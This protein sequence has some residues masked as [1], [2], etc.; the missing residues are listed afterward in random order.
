MKI[1]ITGG[2]G[3]IGKHLVRKLSNSK[4]HEILLLS[5]NLKDDVDLESSNIKLIEGNLSNI[6]EWKYEVKKFGPQATIHMAWEGIPDYGAETSIKNIK[7]GLDLFQMLSEIGCKKIISTGS[8]WEYGKQKGSLNEESTINP[9]NAFTSAKN[10]LH[11]IGKYFAEEKNM[12]FIWTRL[13]YVYGPGQRKISIIP[14]IID[15]IEQGKKPEIKTP[16]AK[17]DF[18]YVEDVVDAIIEI[19]EKGNK[20][21][22]YN[23]G[24]GHLT[25]VKKI[26][27]E[28]YK[29]LN[30][31]NEVGMSKNENESSYGEFWAD[32]SEIKREIGWEPKVNIEE[33]IS[34]IVRSGEKK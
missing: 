25:S 8:C 28:V 26:M 24:S 10:S 30:I 13:F 22:V 33:G 9:N 2:T 3:F 32:I 31:K 4:N 11:W 14:Y 27:D 17:N 5:C 16:S 6:A 34:R 23:I 7:Y 20:S 1:F 15:C 18:I 21:A 19:L 12:Q 29:N